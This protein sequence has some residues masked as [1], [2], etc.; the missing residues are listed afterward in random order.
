MTTITKLQSDLFSTGINVLTRQEISEGVL[1][2]GT[3][4]R[5][6][7]EIGEKMAFQASTDGGQ[8]W[9]EERASAAEFKAAAPDASVRIINF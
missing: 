1:E 2:A 5:D 6:A 7:C 8:C 3:L 4:V 9:C